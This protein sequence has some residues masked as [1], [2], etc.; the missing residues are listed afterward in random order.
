MPGLAP[1]AAAA[2]ELLRR[3]AVW[4]PGFAAAAE[5][6]PTAA[7]LEAAT[8]LTAR[9]VDAVTLQ[10]LAGDPPAWARAD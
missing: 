2:S 9:R 5:H 1:R 10:V 4:R 3:G 8:P 7:S 6:A